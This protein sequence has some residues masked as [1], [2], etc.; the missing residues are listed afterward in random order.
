MSS[1]VS[2][3]SDL[4]K[5]L[6]EVVYSFIETAAHLVQH[7]LNFALNFFSSV[8]NVFVEFFK[9]LIDLAG[10]IASFVLGNVVILL[11]LGAAFFGFLQY[12]RNQG[13]TVKVGNKKLN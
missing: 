13:N 1:I 6:I 12:Q 7:T 2:A 3:L 8:I 9:G 11:V 5:S 10:G 4:V